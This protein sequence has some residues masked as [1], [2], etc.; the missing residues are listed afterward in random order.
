MKKVVI[1]FLFFCV[2]TLNV[3]ASRKTVEFVDCVDGDTIKVNI[4]GKKT[5]VRFLAVDTPETVHPTK[6]EEPFGKDASNYTC[7]RVK[8]AQTLELEFDPKSD[9][10]DKY[11]RA[12][13][14]VWADDSLLQK[15]LI[16]K[17]FA[18]V[19]YLY[20][21]YIHTEELQEAESIAKKNEIGI[22]S[23]ENNVV[24]EPKEEP[25]QEKGFLEELKELIIETIKDFFKDLF[26]DIKKAIKKEIEK[27]FN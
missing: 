4:D 1:I 8:N 25:K 18:K 3:N 9:E 27:I 2:F 6:G 12:L 7:E 24:E 21:D 14:W 20:G 13:A 15:D 26:N 22:W 16:S 23:G 19:D 5:T 11:D 17:G 10:Y